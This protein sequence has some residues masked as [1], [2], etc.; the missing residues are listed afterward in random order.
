MGTIEQSIKTI[1]C[2]GVISVIGYLANYDPSKVPN[3]PLLALSKS[4]VIRG[5]L[6]G[7]KYMLDDL[8]TF[9]DRAKLKLPVE[10]EFGF[11]RDEIVA[12]FKELEA[13]GFRNLCIRV[14]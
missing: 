7:P 4:A 13:G 12:A 14:D 9:V 2:G 6:I 10:K 8:V 3:V 11:T 5:I 1:A